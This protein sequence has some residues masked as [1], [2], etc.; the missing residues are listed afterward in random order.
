MNRKIVAIHQPNFF[1][2]LG[3]FDKITRC[4]LFIFMDNVQFP[5]TGGGTWVNRVKLCINKEPKWVTVP[6]RRS[7]GIHTIC[8]TEI[9]NTAPWRDKLLNTLRLH[10]G[11]TSHYRQLEPLIAE[12]VGYRT[13]LLAD[14]NIHAITRLCSEL[15]FD[16]K[17]LMRGSALQADGSATDLLIEMTKS[18]GGTAYMCGGGAGGY[19]EDEKFRLDDLELVYQNFKHPQYPQHPSADFT[20]GLSILDALCHCGIQGTRELLTTSERHSE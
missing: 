10:Y 14:Y 13:N 6:V 9:D 20:V 15:G 2:W 12:L 16:T 18:V 17:K 5:K 1:P 11:R 7:S 3:Y 8:H 19:Q 4:D